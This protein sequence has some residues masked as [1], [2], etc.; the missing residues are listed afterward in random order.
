MEVAGLVLS[1]W[2]AWGTKH[3]ELTGSRPEKLKDKISL[4]YKELDYGVLTCWEVKLNCNEIDCE[5]QG[6]KYQL[7]WEDLCEWLILPLSTII[8]T[9][10]WESLQGECNNDGWIKLTVESR[11]LEPSLATAYDYE[12]NKQEKAV[13]YCSFTRFLHWNCRIWTIFCDLSHSSSI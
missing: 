10:A 3:F 9:I 1:R 6:N 13:Q 5:D 8:K 11:L 7:G 4:E 12:Q 2:K